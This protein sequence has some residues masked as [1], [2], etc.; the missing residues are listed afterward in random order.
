MARHAIYPPFMASRYCEHDLHFQQ[1]SEDNIK[2]VVLG[3]N[4]RF[5]LYTV[6][7]AEDDVHK[8]R[9]VDAAIQT[10]GDVLENGVVYVPMVDEVIMVKTTKYGWA[11]GYF[12]EES[13]G[14]FAKV[15]CLD[16]GVIVTVEQ[17]CIRVNN[18]RLFSFV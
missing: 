6:C 7:V 5:P 13:D 11:R 16:F 10:Y 18:F 8:F 3:R 12:L 15:F 4:E 17:R 1:R 9:L 14:T 2:L